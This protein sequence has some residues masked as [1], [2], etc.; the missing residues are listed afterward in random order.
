MPT[1]LFAPRSSTIE[2]SS[3]CGRPL[4]ATSPYRAGIDLSSG[5]YGGLLD[6]LGRFSAAE[7][8][9]HGHGIRRGRPNE[10]IAYR[11]EARRLAAA[12]ANAL[13]LHRCPRITPQE[14]LN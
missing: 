9:N 6:A 13:S 12:R 8:E 10:L 7:V 3:R 1:R 5:K 11:K 14:S 2:A 4:L